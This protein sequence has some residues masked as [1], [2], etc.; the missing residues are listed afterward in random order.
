MLLIAFLLWFFLGG[1]GGH[2]FYVGKIV[3]GLVLLLLTLL[4]TF[5]LFALLG[6]LG[7]LLLLII[8]GVWL[9]VD[10]FRIPGWIRRHNDALF[11]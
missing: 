9:I 6:P 11:V 2:R 3:S 5:N 7:I 10:A 4:M 8:P 1:F